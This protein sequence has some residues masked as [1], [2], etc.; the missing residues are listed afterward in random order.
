MTSISK[1]TQASLAHN[2]DPTYLKSIPV[3]PIDMSHEFQRH[4][5]NSY[6]DDS[7]ITQ[8]RPPQQNLKKAKTSIPRDLTQSTETINMGTDLNDISSHIPNPSYTPKTPI[9][10]TWASQI[11]P[12]PQTRPGQPSD[13]ITTR[14]TLYT[15][16]KDR[17]F[18][19]ALQN[20]TIKSLQSPI[21]G[22]TI[23]IFNEAN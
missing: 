16:I 7:S 13:N 17:K 9:C 11:N 6:T 21:E 3:Q 4:T 18:S 22:N 8:T 19:G 15:L 2:P 5:R 1:D 10:P 14:D 23:Q 20:S 12:L